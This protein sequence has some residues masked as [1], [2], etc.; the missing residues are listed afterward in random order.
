MTGGG[1]QAL[2]AIPY[3][4]SENLYLSGGSRRGTYYDSEEDLLTVTMSTV[5]L[6]ILISADSLQGRRHAPWRRDLPHRY[7]THSGSE[8]PYLSGDSRRR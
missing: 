5:A 6:I 7:Y 3:Q 4:G 8:N 1:T 2:L